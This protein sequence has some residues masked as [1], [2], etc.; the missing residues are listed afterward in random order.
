M[1]RL[2]TFILLFICL[3]CNPNNRIPQKG[4]VQPLLEEAKT[5]TEKPKKKGLDSSQ[6][7][8][9]KPPKK[10]TQHTKLEYPNIDKKEIVVEHLGYTSSFNYQNLIPN[11]VAYELTAEEVQGNIKGKDTFS[12]DPKL[13]GKQPTRVDYKNDLQWD[14]GHMAPRADMKW[15]EKAYEESF[16]FSNIC[17]QDHFFNSGDWNQLENKVRKMAVKYGNVYIICGPI[18]TT[19][20]YG[21]LGEVGVVIPDMFFKALLIYNDDRHEY[22]SIAFIMPNEQKDQPLKTYSVTVDVLEQVLKKDL[23]YNLKK[24]GD[25]KIESYIVYTDWEL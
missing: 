6:K 16:Y 4:P 8:T 3:C 15:S 2:L 22:S 23:F 25:E 20:K 17:P 11:W 9:V 24:V 14:K 10:N 18:I 1:R 7:K 12:S 21:K 13:K 5:S 19:N